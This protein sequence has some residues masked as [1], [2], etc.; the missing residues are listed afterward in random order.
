[1]IEEFFKNQYSTEQRFAI[2][3]ALAL[4]A[5]ELA[6]L[7]V[8]GTPLLQDTHLQRIAF[9]TKR[10]PH[11]LHQKYITEIDHT[12]ALRPVRSLL[13]GISQAAIAR[14]KADAAEKLPELTRERQLRI[15][16]PAKVAE[17]Q[18]NAKNV[19]IK[20]SPMTFKPS[21]GFTEVAAE[22][23]VCPL[24]NRFWLFLRDELHLPS[25]P[26][27]TPATDGY[28]VVARPT[29]A[30]DPISHPPPHARRARPQH[31]TRRS[32]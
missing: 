30:A 6:G 16:S 9:P 23:F 31:R 13:D 15:R 22:F 14:T 32:A 1:M 29:P 12:A 5:R 25:L 10:L 2:L 17:V 11:A 20:P 24:I 4:G 3:N 26:R 8:P 7:P 19:G 21:V 27:E 28:A 18:P